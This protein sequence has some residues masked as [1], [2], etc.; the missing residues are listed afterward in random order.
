M[1]IEAWK[2]ISLFAL[3]LLD[4]FAMITLGALLGSGVKKIRFLPLFILVIV[5]SSLIIVGVTVMWLMQILEV[6]NI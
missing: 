5:A 6:S 3:V 1:N 2:L 4:A